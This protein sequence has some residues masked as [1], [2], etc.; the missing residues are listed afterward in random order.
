MKVE[1][2]LRLNTDQ[3]SEFYT[4]KFASDQLSD[5][6]KLLGE[7]NI[8][9]KP[10]RLVVDLG[11]GCGH[12]ARKVSQAFG[13]RV[14]VIDSD[15]TSIKTCQA[16]NGDYVEGILGD[17][18]KPPVTGD[19]QLVCFN[20]VFHHLIGKTEEATRAIQ[21][22][23]LSHWLPSKTMVFVNEYVYDAWFFNLSGKIIYNITK[24]TSLSRLAAAVSRLIPSLRANTFGVGVR[25]R[26]HEEWCELFRDA[27]Y[28]VLSVRRGN[29]EP[30]SFARRLL[31]IRETRRDSFLL[32][33]I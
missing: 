12:F 18:L 29:A 27:G 17:A 33:K 8:S 26:G 16:I 6:E 22:L 14:R 24:S 5:L 13:C 3:I 30:L 25:F 20:L 28:E 15:P 4:E 11:G 21:A 10:E 31:L 32:G 2:Q 7:S 9:L 23:A 19:E 1:E